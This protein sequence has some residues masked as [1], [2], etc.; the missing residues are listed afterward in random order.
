MEKKEIE[1]IEVQESVLENDERREFLEKFGK[2]SATLPIG[3]VLLM[4][5]SQSRAQ[6]S[7]LT[8]V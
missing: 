4:G 6:A 1:N 8:D 3:A 5:P 2:L 7:G